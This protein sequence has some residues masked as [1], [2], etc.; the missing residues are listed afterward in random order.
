[1]M[2]KKMVK[3]I[4]VVLAVLMFISILAVILQVVAVDS[5]AILASTPVTGDNMLDYIIP[6]A[7]LAVAVIVV[8]AC[9]ILP[10]MKKSN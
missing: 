7:I 2:P 3:S 1:M 10:K 9:V 4:A 6:I 8:I 5:A